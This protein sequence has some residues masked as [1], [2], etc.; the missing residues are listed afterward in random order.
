MEPR[1]AGASFML[2]PVRYYLGAHQA[3]RAECG[4]LDTDELRTSRISALPGLAA[5]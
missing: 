1:G 2:D 5:L 4:Y 3:G